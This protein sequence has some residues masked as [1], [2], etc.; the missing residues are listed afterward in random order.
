MA[1]K[2]TISIYIDEDEL[3]RFDK[4]FQTG[5][6][7]DNSRSEAIK[8]AM[9]DSMAVQEA[10]DGLDLEFG[11]RHERK[12]AIRQSIYDWYRRDADE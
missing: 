10:L 4:R 3:D 8:R 9:R 11:H 5:D 6:H 2:T 7:G 12:A 1:E